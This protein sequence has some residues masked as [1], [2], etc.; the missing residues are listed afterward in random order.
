ML[1]EQI[2]KLVKK[3]FFVGNVSIKFLANIVGQNYKIDC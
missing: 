2:E 3:S 1:D